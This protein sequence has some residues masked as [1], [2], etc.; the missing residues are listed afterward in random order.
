MNIEFSPL[1]TAIIDSAMISAYTIRKEGSDVGKIILVDF[2]RNENQFCYLA[3]VRVG[4]NY[5][6]RGIASSSILQI[7]ERICNSYRTGLLHNLAQPIEARTMYQNRGW[8]KSRH[9]PETWEIF[10]RSELCSWNDIN[11][12]IRHVITYLPRWIRSVDQKVN[13][14]SR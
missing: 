5:L 6:K 8:V 11:S 2:D 10:N 14:P 12:S 9:I 13:F 1:S 7:N 3:S 4:S